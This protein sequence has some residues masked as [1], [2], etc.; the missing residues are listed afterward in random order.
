MVANLYGMFVSTDRCSMTYAST[1]ATVNVVSCTPNTNLNVMTIVLGN[2]Q[3]LPSLTSYEM[4]ING[5][6]IDA[7][8]RSNYI[9]FQVMDPT[10]S[11]A[12]EQK[13][14]ILLTSVA[15][16]FPIE[17]SQVNFA[18][19]NPVVFSSLYINFTL[20]RALNADEAFALVLSKDFITLNNIPS[21][22]RIR[23]LQSDGVT[24]IPATWV[25]KVINSQIIF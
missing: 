16:S 2:T 5:I 11:Y 24:A 15:R 25:M 9:T 6:S 3:R 22:I 8:Q 18:I 20:P 10:G 13:T 19:N 14:V 12:I 1:H 4:L 23:L 7:S 17:V 21:K